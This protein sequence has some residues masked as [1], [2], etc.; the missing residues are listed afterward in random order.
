MCSVWVHGPGACVSFAVAKFLVLATEELDCSRRGLSTSPDRAQRIFESSCVG[1]A[2]KQRADNDASH[3]VSLQRTHSTSFA[4]IP[5]PRTSAREHVRVEI[6]VFWLVFC[7]NGLKC[8]E[9]TITRATF[10]GLQHGRPKAYRADAARYR[11]RPSACCGPREVTSSRAG[12][13]RPALPG[14]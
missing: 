9:A 2:N 8:C 13:A 3:A 7:K 4:S 11:S 6:R 1:Q 5:P 12:R 14:S 10:A